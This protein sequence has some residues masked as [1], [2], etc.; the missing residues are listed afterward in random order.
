MT[1]NNSGSPI[2]DFIVLRARELHQELSNLVLDIHLLHDCSTVICN[3][4]FPIR[5]NKHFIKTFRAERCPESIR[6]LLRRQY[7]RL[8]SKQKIKM[9]K[10]L[11]KNKNNQIILYELQGH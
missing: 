4:H 5:T 2:A 6:N 7:M 1:T 9:N 8:I 3:S 10:Y 11:I